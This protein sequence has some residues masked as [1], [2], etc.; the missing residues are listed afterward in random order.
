MHLTHIL[1]ST[2]IHQN[3]VLLISYMY[4]TWNSIV[5]RYFYSW[6]ACVDRVISWIKKQISLYCIYAFYTKS[7]DFGCKIYLIFY[8]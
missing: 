4:I 7:N 3:I 6:A 5:P 2:L 8:V 1:N